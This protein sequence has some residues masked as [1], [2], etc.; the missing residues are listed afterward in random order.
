MRGEY[1]IGRV[2]KLIE[3]CKSITRYIKLSATKL[4]IFQMGI[5]CMVN[6]GSSQFPAVLLHDFPTRN[7]WIQGSIIQIFWSTGRSKPTARRQR[8]YGK[9]SWRVR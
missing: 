4:A 8:W 5:P 1:T 7:I 3:T 9:E 6:M 2:S